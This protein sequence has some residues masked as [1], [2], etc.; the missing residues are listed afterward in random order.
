M[1]GRARRP[2]GRSSAL[3]WLLLLS[4]PALVPLA[5]IATAI[6][7]PEAEVWAHLAQHVLPR[8]TAN[9]LK[10]VIGVAMLA[11]TI[12]TLLA[13][14]TALCDFPGRRFFDAALLLPLAIP[15]YVL[16]FVAVGFLDYAGPLQSWLR[17]SFGSSQWFPPIRSTG[18]AIL[19]LALTTYPYVYLLARSAFLTQGRRALEAAQTLGLRRETAAWRVALPMARPWIAAG[20]ALVTMETLADFGAVSVFNYDTFTTAIYRAWSGLFSVGAALELAGVLMVFVVIVLVIERKSRASARFAAARDTTRSSPRLVLG[21]VARVAACAI[22]SIVFL[23]AFALPLLQLVAWA[24]AYALQDLDTRYFGFLLRSVSLSASAALVIVAASVFL[25]YTARRVPTPAT[26]GLVRVATIGYAIP[27]TVLAIGVLVPVALLNNWLLTVLRTIPGFEHATLLLHGTLITVLFAYLA[28]FLAVGF[29]PIESG[30]H[31]VTHN[32]DE[33]AIGLGVT[34]RALLRKVHL[35]LLRT[36]VATAA[37]LVFV[38][39]MKEMPI[40]L[41][42]RPPGW[43]TLAVRVW[44]MTSEGEWERAALPAIAIVVT[45]LVPAFLLTRRE[46][47]VA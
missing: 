42:T 33:A 25:A 43:D 20:V 36:G 5:V 44:E 24:A 17:A 39:V 2:R 35:P 6:L 27:G 46:A 41:I 29:G 30:L 31:R 9:T 10:L 7:S 14:F 45:G 3:G 40:T 1:S 32:L 23:A 13:W 4:L 11:G 28:R 18:G 21:P 15:A 26:R 34:G 22:C 16:A 37:T 19:V 47:H 8:V 38:D 12:G